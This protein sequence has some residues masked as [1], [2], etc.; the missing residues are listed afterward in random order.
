MNFVNGN[1]FVED[2]KYYL[3]ISLTGNI[4]DSLDTWKYYGGL[5]TGKTIK[6]YIGGDY[7]RTTSGGLTF[8]TGAIFNKNFRLSA[9]YTPV[10]KAVPMKKI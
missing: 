4:T 7:T 6:A 1:R 3:H 8:S 5:I 10:K 9:Y 2:I